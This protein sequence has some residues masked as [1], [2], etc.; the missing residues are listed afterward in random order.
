[1][2]R[3]LIVA[4]ALGIL[5]IAAPAWAGSGYFIWRPPE[6][7]AVGKILGFKSWERFLRWQGCDASIVIW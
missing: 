3:S 4:L 2:R 5:V 7:P 6:T 1:M